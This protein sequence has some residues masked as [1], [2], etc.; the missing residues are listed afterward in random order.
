MTRHSLFK[1]HSEKSEW[2]GHGE[3]DEQTGEEKGEARGGHK[4]GAFL[5]TAFHGPDFFPCRN[6]LLLEVA[7]REHMILSD[8]IT[9]TTSFR[10]SSS[11]KS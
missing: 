8:C 11:Y 4:T 1:A 2:E 6:P 10:E 3:H 7:R 9:C 5:L